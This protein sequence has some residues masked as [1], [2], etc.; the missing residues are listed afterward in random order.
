MNAT[1][2]ADQIAA[3]LGNECADLL[4]AFGVTNVISPAARLLIAGWEHRQLQ[5]GCPAEFV[6]RASDFAVRLHEE[7]MNGGAGP[8]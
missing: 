7:R 1:A 2:L 6:T 4:S 8:S 5:A 3:R